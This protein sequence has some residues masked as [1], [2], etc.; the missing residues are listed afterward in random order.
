MAYNND[1]AT[2]AQKPAELRRQIVEQI[3]QM[4]EASQPP[5]RGILSDPYTIRPLDDECGEPQDLRFE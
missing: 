1:G 2:C 5:D 4:R 3:L